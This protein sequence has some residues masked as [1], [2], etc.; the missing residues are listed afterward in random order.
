MFDT[1]EQAEDC[2]KAMG[3]VSDYL[4]HQNDGITIKGQHN[5]WSHDVWVTGGN[6][7]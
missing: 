1:V 6:D 7:E 3:T 4:I 2:I 5:G